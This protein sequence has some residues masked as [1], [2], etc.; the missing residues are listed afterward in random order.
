MS[1]DFLIDESL[2]IQLLKPNLNIEFDVET[3]EDLY[4]INDMINI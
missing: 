3:V 4:R 2:N 1:I